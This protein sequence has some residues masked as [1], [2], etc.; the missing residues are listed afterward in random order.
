MTTPL[1]NTTTT[2]PIPVTLHSSSPTRITFQVS[3]A[4]PF[5]MGTLILSSRPPAPG[6]VFGNINP[7]AATLLSPTP[8]TLSMGAELATFSNFISS[9]SGALAVELTYDPNSWLVYDCIPVRVGGQ[10][11]AEVRAI[12]AQTCAIAEGVVSLN[13]TL[14]ALLDETQRQSARTTKDLRQP[15]GNSKTAGAPVKG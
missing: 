11:L 1:I 9:W 14:Q 7:G 13:L 4:A 6:G 15:R 3:P 10:I 5:Y 8:Q 12:H 2:G